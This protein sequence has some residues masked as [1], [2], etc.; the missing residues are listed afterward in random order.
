MERRT[1]LAVVLS[2]VVVYAYQAFFVPKA[3][4]EPV[5]SVTTESPQASGVAAPD[6]RAST[7]PSPPQAVQAAPQ[8]DELLAATVVGD[9]TEREIVVETDAVRAVFTN[10]GGRLKNWILKNY[11]DSAGRLVDLV[12]DA[13]PTDQPLPFSLG[14]DEGG[15]GQRLNGAIFLATTRD[16]NRLPGVVFDFQD[17]SGLLARKEFRFG[18]NAFEVTFTTSVRQGG[19]ALNPS[20]E[21]G[22]GLGDL[23]FTGGG[24]FPRSRGIPT[25][26]ALFHDGEDV[27]RLSL[28]NAAESPASDGTFSFVGV[29]DHYFIAA[30][31][32]TGPLLVEYRPLTLPA[33]DDP[34]G[35]RQ[36][37][38]HTIRPASHSMPLRYYI[39]P[40]SFEDLRAIDGEFVRAIDFGFLA[41]IA[42][43]FLSAL[44]WIYGYVGNYGWSI[45]VLTILMNIVMAPLRHKSV[46][47][48]RKM[49]E[50]QP[51]LKAIQDRYAGLKATDPARQKMNSEVMGLYREK[52]ANPA[53]GCIPMLLQ[54][55]F[56]F[57]F[58]SL[59]SQAVELR[60]A[61]FGFWIQDLSEM[62]PYYVTPLLMGATMFWQQRLT[63]ATGDPTQ[64]RM[65]MF[66]PVVFVAMFL[67]FPSGLA[68]YYFTQNLWAIGQQI[69]TNR[70]IGPPIVHAQRPAAERRVKSAGAGRTPRAEQKP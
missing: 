23:R 17:E 56:L 35:E 25:P 26:E 63:P 5:P 4:I 60:G 9:T 31:V 49:Q 58:Y 66:M 18:P 59:L 22:P 10:R 65:M 29:N 14:L 67:T 64:Q 55:P 27:T 19:Q 53:S 7:A 45:V 34:S 33:S 15:I 69:V 43:P 37:L 2:F 48:M 32:N 52:G 38:I 20:I 41:F 3:P 21:W 42:V 13:V 28:S 62:D 46:V 50:I 70:I 1:L 40:K 11:T 68:I 6:G 61:P 44:K 12:P 39:G 51:Q 54:F 24:S 57:A 47:S 36:L 8:S 30:A 16:S